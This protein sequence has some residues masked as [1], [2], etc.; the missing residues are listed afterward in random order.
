MLAC[1]LKIFQSSTKT[2]VC[3]GKEWGVSLHFLMVELERVPG[4]KGLLDNF[5]L[6]PRI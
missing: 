1:R 2:R 3:S 4:F 6:K 5:I